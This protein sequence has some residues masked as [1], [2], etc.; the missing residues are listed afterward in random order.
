VRPWRRRW[1]VAE[2]ASAPFSSSDHLSPSLAHHG[3]PK[4]PTT[5]HT[6]NVLLK[7]KVSS[8][9]SL[10]LRARVSCSASRLSLSLP[11]PGPQSPRAAWP[12]FGHPQTSSRAGTESESDLNFHPPVRARVRARRP[13]AWRH[14]QRNRRRSPPNGDAGGDGAAATTQQHPPPSSPSSSSPSSRPTPSKSANL[15]D[16]ALPLPAPLSS[17]LEA[18]AAATAATAPALVR[19]AEPSALGRAAF[20]A[21]RGTLAKQATA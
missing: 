17:T 19:A 18:S 20:A 5:T 14:R 2:A 15:A 10:S 6:H 9:F 4:K 1:R 7:D 8:R 12:T 16:Q 13:G 21:R 11:L 3:Y